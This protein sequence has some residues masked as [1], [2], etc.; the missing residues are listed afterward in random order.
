MRTSEDSD[1]TG[2]MPRLI[3][4]FA[5]RTATLLVLSCR[6][7]FRKAYLRYVIDYHMDSPTA[8]NCV[9]LKMRRKEA[10]PMCDLNRFWN[11]MHMCLTHY[12]TLSVNSTVRYKS[13]NDLIWFL[14]SNFKTLNCIEKRRNNRNLVSEK[15]SFSKENRPGIEQWW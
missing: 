12:R 8:N 3:W 5:G 6:D 10:W 2:R 11:T 9:R 4:V 13:Q 1:Q 7:S 15:F 14:T